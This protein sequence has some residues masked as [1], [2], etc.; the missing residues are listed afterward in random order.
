MYLK[1]TSCTAGSSWVRSREGPNA[2]QT[3]GASPLAL[4][5]SLTFFGEI[6]SGYSTGIS[7]A[8]NPIDFI[9]GNRLTVSVVKGDVHN[10]VLTANFT[11]RLTRKDFY[12]EDFFDTTFIVPFMIDQCPGNVQT[13]G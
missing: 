8:S 7:T 1:Q 4:S 11:F 5:A 10:Q 13:K 6:F 9:F 2:P 3:T 12:N